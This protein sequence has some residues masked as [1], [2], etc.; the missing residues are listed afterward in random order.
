MNIGNYATF[1]FLYRNVLC[2]D[3]FA[4]LFTILIQELILKKNLNSFL[5]VMNFTNQYRLKYFKIR[6]KNSEML[7]LTLGILKNSKKST[8]RNAEICHI[9]DQIMRKFRVSTKFPNL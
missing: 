6:N 9:E 3:L 1:K 2:F 5:S 7:S 8:L 4:S